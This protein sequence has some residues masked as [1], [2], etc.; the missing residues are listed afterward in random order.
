M[1]PRMIA[2]EK[3]EKGS[4]KKSMKKLILFCRKYWW[5]I[6][7]SIVFGAV[8][9]VFQIIGPNKIKDMIADE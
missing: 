8:S 2:A 6:G 5:W 3:A 1:P 7:L 9:V 4:F